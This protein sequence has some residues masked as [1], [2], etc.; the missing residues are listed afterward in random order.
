MPTPSPP[1]PLTLAICPPLYMPEVGGW[2]NT[3]SSR[4]EPEAT[5]SRLPHNHNVTECV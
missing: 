4:W 5:T 2:D 1:H 3:D